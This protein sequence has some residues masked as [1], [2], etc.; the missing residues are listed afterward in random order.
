M[1]SIERILNERA[2][3]HGT[4]EDVARVHTHLLN[5]TELPGGYEMTLAQAVNMICHK[6]ARAVVGNAFEIDHWRDIAGYAMLAVKHIEK[7]GYADTDR[8]TEVSERG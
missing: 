3:T 6:L 1:D 5:A 8:Q 7:C 2:G 4:F